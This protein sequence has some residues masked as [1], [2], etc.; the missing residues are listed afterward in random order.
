MDQQDWFAPDVSNWDMDITTENS[1]KRSFTGSMCG[2]VMVKGINLGHFIRN[3]IPIDRVWYSI[4]NSQK[5][6]CWQ[7]INR[8]QAER[9]NP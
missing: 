8:Q 2:G 1:Q 5:K 9:S 3:I 6:H 4:R 7:K